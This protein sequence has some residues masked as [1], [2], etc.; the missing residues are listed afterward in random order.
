MTDS[1]V[2][3][4]VA[5]TLLLLTVAALSWWGRR[6]PYVPKQQEARLAAI[7]PVAE[8]TGRRDVEATLTAAEKAIGRASVRSRVRV[9]YA[10]YDSWHDGN[11]GMAHRECVEQIERGVS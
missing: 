1:E 7:D 5:I 11:P 4:T 2:V 10:C 8:F 3:L 6:P 9:H